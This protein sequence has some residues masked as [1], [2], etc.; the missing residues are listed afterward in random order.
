MGIN[1]K[2]YR[3]SISMMYALKVRQMN[4]LTFITI[5]QVT[6]KKHASNIDDFFA[7][8]DCGQFH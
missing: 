7:W 5:T 6:P 8:S 1:H 3:V 4:K 2:V